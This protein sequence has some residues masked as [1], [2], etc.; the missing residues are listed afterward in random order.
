MRS[1]NTSVKDFSCSTHI[2]R[3]RHEMLMLTSGVT[4]VCDIICRR[5]FVIICRKL[6]P[7]GSWRRGPRK[8]VNVRY[9][10]VSCSNRTLKVGAVAYGRDESEVCFRTSQRLI[11]HPRTDATDS[12]T[13]STTNN[14]TSYSLDLIKAALLI[15]EP[16]KEYVMGPATRKWKFRARRSRLPRRCLGNKTGRLSDHES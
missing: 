13:R 16:Q 15:S 5:Y 3:S 9:R 11:V 12:G 14:V 7:R 1:S 4:V 6:F 2:M 8:P 10:A